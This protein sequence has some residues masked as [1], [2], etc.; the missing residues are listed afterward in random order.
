MCI[1]TTYQV[2]SLH[3]SQVSLP[4][5]KAEQEEGNT[6]PQPPGPDDRPITDEASTAGLLPQDSI[7]DSKENIDTEEHF[8][9]NLTILTQGKEEEETTTTQPQGP[10]NLAAANTSYV[11][12]QSS[13]SIEASETDTEKEI[14]LSHDDMTR[15]SWYSNSCQAW[16]ILGFDSFEEMKEF[17][18]ELSTEKR[19]I[20]EQA[21]S[22]TE[23]E[24]FDRTIHPAYD[25]FMAV[26]KS[27]EPG[28]AYVCVDYSDVGKTIGLMEIQTFAD[29]VKSGAQFTHDRKCY[30]EKKCRTVIKT[31][32]D[33]E[34]FQTR[35]NFIYVS[36]LYL[37]LNHRFGGYNIQDETGQLLFLKKLNRQWTDYVFSR[38][39]A[40]FQNRQYVWTF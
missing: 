39:R 1:P 33:K 7:I 24:R 32:L 38:P 3:E 6:A 34:R 26:N 17:Q 20:R 22:E 30:Q 9:L 12:R 40:W 14:P 36:S 19:R 21:T 10:K 8:T 28:S 25:V 31:L 13:T 23:R 35:L 16:F 29:K 5:G 2:V 15:E 37:S 4:R 11:W 27:C 18:A